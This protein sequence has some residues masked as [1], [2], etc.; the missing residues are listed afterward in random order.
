[1]TDFS[2]LMAVYKGE[3]DSFLYESLE[4]IY[5]QSIKPSEVVLIKDGELTA[6]LNDVIEFFSNQYENLLVHGY[7][8]N[9][10]LGYALDYG[11]RLCK[12][13]IIFR[14]DSDDINVV[15]RF[16]KQ[17][18]ILEETDAVIV[19]GSIEEFNL[20]P[21]DLKRLRELPEFN[22]DIQNFKSIRNPFNHMSVAFRKIAIEN[23]GGYKD[24]PGYEDYYLWLR[25][26]EKY[27]GYNIQKVLVHARVGNDMISRRQGVDFMLKELRFQKQLLNDNLISKK[28]YVRNILM[29]VSIRMMPIKYLTG[30]YNIFLRRSL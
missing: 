16:E 27:E 1:M 17:I 3:K 29:R 20:K 21:G 9:K 12:N 22:G 26:L 18:Q 10:G 25:V 15:D 13:D 24:M 28:I 7:K 30:F 2:V 11:L 6:E 14:C 5:N 19:G 4:S 23:S 8:K